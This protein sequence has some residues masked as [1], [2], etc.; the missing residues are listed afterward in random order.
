MKASKPAVQD[1]EQKW[2]RLYMKLMDDED[3]MGLSDAEFKTWVFCLLTT[4]ANGGFLPPN[5]TLAFKRRKGEVTIQQH[6]EALTAARLLTEISGELQPT[7]WKKLQFDSDVSTD[8]VRRFRNVKRSGNE[9]FQKR[10]GNGKETPSE[11]RDRE[12]KENPLAPLPFPALES[13]VESVV[14]EFRG[15]HPKPSNEQAV[16][17]FFAEHFMRLGE[18]IALF[19]AWLGP[20]RASL[21]AWCAH[22]ESNG[23]AYAPKLEAWLRDGSWL[24]SPPTGGAIQKPKFDPSALEDE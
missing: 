5:K 17:V 8:R 4:K 18:E 6:I 22:W 20:I 19:S 13:P 2:I 11:I 15:K 14:Q 9:T 1:K 7:G 12:L 23:T 16:A 24:K 21:A 3:V 10:L